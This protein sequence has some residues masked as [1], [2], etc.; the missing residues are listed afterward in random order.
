VREV[1]AREVGEPDAV[2]R[3]Y[4][5]AGCLWHGAGAGHLAGAGQAILAP[6]STHIFKRAFACRSFVSRHMNYPIK[7]ICEISYI[8]YRTHM[9]NFETSVDRKYRGHG[10]TEMLF[11]NRT[12]ATR[13]PVFIIRRICAII[14]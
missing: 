13:A 11:I 5:R 2:G 14:I 12:R 9:S 7:T 6:S 8:C 3:Q 1:S 10:V 4:G